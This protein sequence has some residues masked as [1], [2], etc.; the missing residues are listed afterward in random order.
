M[1]RSPN[2]GRQC[3]ACWVTPSSAKGGFLN[4]ATD[5]TTLITVAERKLRS[6]AQSGDERHRDC[7]RSKSAFLTTSKKERRQRWPF[8]ASSAQDECADAFRSVNLVATEADQIDARIPQIIDGFAEPLGGVHVEESIVRR[9][10][11]SD[12]R[13]RLHYAGLIVHVHYGDEESCGALCRLD[14][15]GGNAPVR[16][17]FSNCH[18][19]S[20][21]GQMFERLEDGLVLDGVLIETS[22]LFGVAGGR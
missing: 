9:K 12:L 21:A 8:V 16:C 11:F 6:L 2:R 13:Q 22:S 3:L 20:M 1:P 4:L 18:L 7:S 5:G 19:E 10:H 14:P 15:A 17:G